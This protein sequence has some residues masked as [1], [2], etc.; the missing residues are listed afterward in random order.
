MLRPLA[1]GL[2]RRGYEVSEQRVGT[3]G[4]GLKL[5]M[6]LDAHHERVIPDLTGFHE[7]AIG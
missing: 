1:D 5:R 4:S 7:M 2:F 3:I 6:K